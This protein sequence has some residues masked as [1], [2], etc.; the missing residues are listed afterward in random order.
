MEV[1]DLGI[2]KYEDALRIQHEILKERINGNIP[3]T[4]IITE[5]EESIVLGRTSKENSIKDRSY[6]EQK[7]IPIIRVAR[8]G[9]IAYH[10]PGQ[11]VLYPIVDLKEREKDISAY[12]DILEEI[13]VGA[14]KD[15]GIPAER[16]KEKR[17]VWVKSKKIA[18]IGIAI[19]K[20]VTFHGMVIN[21]N[22]DLS[23]FSFIHP[24]GE[25]DIE[26]TSLKDVLGKD[27]N[28]S[29]VKDAFIDRSE[30]KFSAENKVFKM[31]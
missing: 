18:F 12:I 13:A 6:F 2:T 22:N 10:A 21:I 20:W 11:L 30:E 27:M 19:K 29:V 26:V 7:D 25:S 5:H 31:V 9:K 28:M 17:G 23:A 24:C 16:G 1:C 4:L 8:G 14:L 3:D 15:L